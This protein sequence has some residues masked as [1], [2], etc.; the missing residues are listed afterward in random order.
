MVATMFGSLNVQ[1]RVAMSPRC[2]ATRSANRV[3]RSAVAGSIQPPI[4]ATQRGVVK[5]WSVTVA[6][7]PCS[8]QLAHMRR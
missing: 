2:S 6:S 5:W 4:R 3:N 8:R 7:R 1:K